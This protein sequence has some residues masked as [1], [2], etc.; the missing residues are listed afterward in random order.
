MKKNEN[1]HN[2]SIRNMV[3]RTAVFSLSALL[4]G[5]FAAGNAAYA[6]EKDSVKLLSVEDDGTDVKGGLDVS[7]IVEEAM[8]SVV[9]ITTKTVQEVMNYYGM[10]GFGGYAP[11]QYEV[12]NGGSG[13]IIGKN[14][15]ELLIATNYHVVEGSS[16]LSVGFADNE[17]YP[18][19]LKGYDI[20]KDLAVVSVALD[21][22]STDTLRAISIAKIG[23]SDD[24]KVG[25]QV[26]AIGNALGFGESVTTGI[27]SSKNRRIDNSTGSISS[28]NTDGVNLIQTDAAINPGNSGGALLN[29][30]G[31]VVGINSAKSASTYVE[32]IGYAIAISDVEDTLERLMNEEPREQLSGDEHGV[33]GISTFSVS[34][35]D[36]KRYGFP[37]GA[38][39]AEISEGS[40]AE[41]A[42]LPVGGIITEFDGKEVNSTDD[43]FS[44]ISY[45][46]PGEEVEVVVSFKN[47]DGE[48]EEGSY[49]V[50][51]HEQDVHTNSS[52]TENDGASEDADRPDFDEG[53]SFGFGEMPEFHDFDNFFNKNGSYGFFE[54]FD[55]N[56]GDK[57]ENA[58][59]D[60]D[61]KNGDSKNNSKSTLNTS[62]QD[63]RS[64]EDIFSE[65]EQ[66]QFGFNR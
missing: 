53:S 26:V 10:F 28:K 13:I 19:K 54:D 24:L 7:D 66:K 60:S 58:D 11:R 52:D 45:Y 49:M 55:Y 40:G 41:E 43:L 3:K 42:G 18:A 51:L 46:A 56:K 14:D 6:N 33:L 37:K 64:R 8:P 22:I 2:D 57:E 1:K 27:V 15:D 21:D 12:Q 59:T 47:D 29:M 20:D 39:I 23:S 34:D 5:S 31:E 61:K 63:S 32:G 48:F 50:T 44:Y 17:A 30:K 4:I 62:E 16:D 9:T 25:E 35:M 36:S 38:Y 65:C